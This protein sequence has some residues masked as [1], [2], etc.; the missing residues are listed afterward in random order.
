M[1]MIRKGQVKKVS[2]G[3]ILGQVALVSSLFGGAASTEEEGSALSVGSLPDFLQHSQRRRLR[4][5]EEADAQKEVAQVF[6]PF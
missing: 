3:D 4:G 5:I 6:F 2:K 1:N